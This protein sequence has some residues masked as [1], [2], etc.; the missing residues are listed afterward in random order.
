MVLGIGLGVGVGVWVGVG[1]MVGVG[2][3]V[4]VVVGTGGRGGRGG[5]HRR[6]RVGRVSPVSVAAEGVVVEASPGV[7]VVCHRRFLNPQKQKH[8]QQGQQAGPGPQTPFFAHGCYLS[9][10]RH[11]QAGALPGRIAK[12]VFENGKET[13]R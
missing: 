12:A 10:P 13:G 5:R 4:G 6:R 9:G 8:R 1:V 11:V 7:A 2:V 3:W